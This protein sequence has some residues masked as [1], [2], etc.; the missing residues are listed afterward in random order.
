[1]LILAA[2]HGGFEIKESIKNVLQSK[3]IDVW[4]AGDKKLDPTDDYPDFVKN[5][6]SKLKENIKENRAILFCRSG[7]GEVIT[8][9]KF[10]KIRATI[11]WNVEHAKKSR[12]HNDANVL[13]IPADYITQKEA[14][15]IVEAWLNTP[16]SG[17][18]RHVRRLKKISDIENEIENNKALD[19]EKVTGII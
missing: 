5:A 10:T 14:L 13:A 6:I 4:D 18:E 12:E 15:E 1:M 3:G 17:D 2:D 8:A 9:N 11:S 19:K 16:F 7:S